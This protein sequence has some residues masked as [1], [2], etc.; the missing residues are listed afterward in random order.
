MTCA[1]RGSREM[2]ARNVHLVSREINVKIVQRDSK[3]KNVIPAFLVTM[4][5]PVVS[6]FL[7][8]H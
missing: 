6:E 3:E 2:V 5:T 7:L 8:K 4:V 1:L